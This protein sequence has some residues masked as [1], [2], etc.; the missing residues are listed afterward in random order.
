MPN[1]TRKCLNEV[2]LILIG[3]LSL[4]VRNRVQR[5]GSQ[6]MWE[7]PKKGRWGP[8]RISL[9]LGLEEQHGLN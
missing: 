6:T 2:A 3:S 4:K 9:S 5:S 8:R 7:Q 1:T